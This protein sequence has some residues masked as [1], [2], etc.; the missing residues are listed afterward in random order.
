MKY[1]GM[2]LAIT[3][4]VDQKFLERS[5]AFAGHAEFGF[6]TQCTLDKEYADAYKKI[7]KG[8]EVTVLGICLG[9]DKNDGP[10]IISRCIVR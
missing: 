5:F 10:L 3:G 7:Q 2:T 8:N 4:L 9:R 6:V 1:T